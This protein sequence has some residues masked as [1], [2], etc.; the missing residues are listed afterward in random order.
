MFALISPEKI[1]LPPGS[2]VRKKQAEWFEKV[3][4]VIR[5]LHENKMPAMG[6]GMVWFRYRSTQPTSQNF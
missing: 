3:K 4:Y 2:V 6:F 1:Q 5:D